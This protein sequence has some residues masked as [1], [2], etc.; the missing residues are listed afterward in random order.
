[1]TIE[2]VPGQHTMQLLIGGHHHIPR[3]PPVL[4]EPVTITVN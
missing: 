3:N 2:L 4:S 1:M